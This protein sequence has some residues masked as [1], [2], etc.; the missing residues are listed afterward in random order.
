MDKV[1]GGHG[2]SI[3]GVVEGKPPS[4]ASSGKA[5]TSMFGCEEYTNQELREIILQRL[6][7]CERAQLEF[8]AGIASITMPK[9]P[10]L[11]KI[12][13]FTKGAKELWS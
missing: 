6:P 13:E 5:G 7:K 2:V 10:E 12:Y 4:I 9:K 3:A 1:Q 8:M 11:A